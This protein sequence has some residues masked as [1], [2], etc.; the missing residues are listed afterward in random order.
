MNRKLKYSFIGICSVVI[1]L[2]AFFVFKE[3]QKSRPLFNINPLAFS[4]LPNW[5][6]DKLSEVWP[7]FSRSCQKHK[8]LPKETVFLNG[9]PLSEWSEVC[10]L[11]LSLKTPT[12]V[13]IRNFFETH[14]LP[15]K[16]A[17]EGTSEGLFTGYYE[18]EL[19]GSRTKYNQYIAPIYKR[20]SDLV[21]VED[22]GIFRKDRQ[23]L[24]GM[25]IAGRVVDGNLRP[26]FTHAEI[27]KG[28]LAGNELVWVEDPI[29][30][31]F[32]QIQGSGAIKLDTGETT[33]LTYAGTNGQPYT[34]IGKVLIE[35]GELT[36]ENVSMQSIRAWLKEHPTEAKTVME[37]NAS[38]VFFTETKGEGPLG[39][40][41]VALTPGRSL[42]VD[43]VY[44]SYGTPVWLD[45]TYPEPESSRIQRLVIAQ[46]KGGA[47]KGPIRGDVFWGTGV[48]AGEL[49]GIMKSKGSYYIL[50]PKSK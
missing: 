29:D 40:E 35:R 10:S 27:D 20:P 38:F 3:W 31:F 15:Y 21:M 37:E 19:K 8:T 34:A 25:R 22:L 46:D 9:K 16:V 5:N 42:A 12:E 44:I 4:D 14:F 36:R 49:A 45:I 47:I 33:R 13:E 50:L 6:T 18:P 24:K 48:E 32:V 30:A 23:E 7:A 2:V 28:A 1:L 39:A 17:S 11:A 41:G 26:Y 43:P